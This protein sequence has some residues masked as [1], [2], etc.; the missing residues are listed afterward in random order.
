MKDKL[1]KVKKN[2][3]I[4]LTERFHL[5]PLAEEC[6]CIATVPAQGQGEV[7][8]DAGRGQ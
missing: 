2:Y 8:G 5:V 4:I 7:A 6:I 3:D 1:N